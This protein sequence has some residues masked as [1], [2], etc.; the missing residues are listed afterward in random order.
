MRTFTFRSLTSL[1][2]LWLLYGC[3]APQLPSPSADIIPFVTVKEAIPSTVPVVRYGRYTLVEMVPEPHQR[4]LLQQVVEVTIPPR[5]GATVG[6]ALQHIL[7]RSGYQLCDLSGISPLATLP[8]PAAH[9]RL[10]PLSLRDGLLTLSGASWELRVD[11]NLRQIC[12]VRVMPPE[13]DAGGPAAPP[14]M[15]PA[16]DSPSQME[17]PLAALEDRT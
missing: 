11:D 2:S 4:D 5:L 14:L 10:G 13:L 3:V 8:L 9:Y 7:L 16:S 6:D 15:L 12:F 17:T 1:L